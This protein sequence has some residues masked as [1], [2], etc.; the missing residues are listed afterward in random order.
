MKKFTI[1]LS[2][3]A[4]C[5][6]F[7]PLAAMD[8]MFQANNQILL[9]KFRMKPE[10]E[11]FLTSLRTLLA[12]QDFQTKKRTIDWLLSPGNLSQKYG[13]NLTERRHAQLSDLC[14]R[15]RTSLR[16]QGTLKDRYGVEAASHRAPIDSPLE[17]SYEVERQAVEQKTGSTEEEEDDDEL[18][19]TDSKSDPLLLLKLSYLRGLQ[20]CYKPQELPEKEVVMRH[21][22]LKKN[23]LSELIEE[24]GLLLMLQ[25][26]DQVSWADTILIST[27][28]VCKETSK[29]DLFDVACLLSR[30][31]RLDSCIKKLLRTLRN[32]PSK[33]V[34]AVNRC[35]GSFTPLHAIAQSGSTS[36]LELSY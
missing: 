9:P 5:I 23:D 15:R 22:A 25:L 13:L 3:I 1:F 6:L 12:K 7:I 16:E 34:N 28:E 27:H 19:N 17:L 18:S 10:W 21:L 14:S 8:S 30:N 26:Q 35:V 29:Y 33:F 11:N 20:N 24:A 4:Y 31:G 36:T 32:E 2:L